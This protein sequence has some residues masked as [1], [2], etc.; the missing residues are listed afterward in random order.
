MNYYHIAIYLVLGL[1]SAYIVY[2]Q[3]KYI[4]IQTL[5]I[6]LLIIAFGPLVLLSALVV[7]TIIG[8]KDIGDKTPILFD[9]RKHD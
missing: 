1:A 6:S 8:L 7:S 5:L 3:E 2:A 9:W 4:S